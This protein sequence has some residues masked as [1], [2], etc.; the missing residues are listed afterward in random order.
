MR[1]RITDSVSF[2][3]WNLPSKYTKFEGR[4]IYRIFELCS[5]MDKH[6]GCLHIL[7][8]VNND[9]INKQMQLSLQYPVF[10]SL[11]DSTEMRFLD[12]IVVLF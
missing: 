3:E 4:C 10:L 8:I 9:S 1:A 5:P 2:P 7:A 12:C 6:L 11:D